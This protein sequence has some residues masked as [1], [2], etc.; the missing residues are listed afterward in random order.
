[1]R[2]GGDGDSPDP[3][4]GSW[5]LSGLPQVVQNAA[6]GGGSAPQF[7]HRVTGPSLPDRRD[8]WSAPYHRGSKEDPKR[9]TARSSKRRRRPESSRSRRQSGRRRGRPHT[10][11]PSSLAPSSGSPRDP[12]PA[13]STPSALRRSY[14]PTRSS[15]PGRQVPVTLGG[16]ESTCQ[17][18]A[19]GLGAKRGADDQPYGVTLTRVK[20]PYLRTREATWGT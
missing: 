18:G 13:R 14:R 11:S 10:A 2:E 4:G 1:M 8:R 3:L 15:C 9:M 19:A 5:P 12:Q 7:Q 16:C 17:H 20:S 6:P